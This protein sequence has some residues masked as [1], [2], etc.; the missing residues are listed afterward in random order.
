MIFGEGPIIKNI[1]GD[2]NKLFLQGSRVGQPITNVEGDAAADQGTADLLAAMDPV[3]QEVAVGMS[4]EE[5]RHYTVSG[6]PPLSLANSLGMPLRSWSVDVSPYQEGAG[7]PAPDNVRPIHGTNKLN[8]FVAD[9]Y[10]PTAA[11]T[12]VIDVPTLSA[13]K[14]DEE[15]EVGS[16]S[17]TG[18]K[19]PTGGG[20]IRSANKIS[21]LPNTSYYILKGVYILCQYSE[22]ED[23]ISFTQLGVDSPSNTGHLFTTGATTHYITFATHANY[24]STYNHDIAIN[25]PSTV[26]TY[27]PYN[28]TV[29]TGTIGSEGGESRSAKIV[30]TGTEDFYR[31]ETINGHWRF[32]LAVTNVEKS[33]TPNAISNMYKACNPNETYLGV[34]GVSHNST[35]SSLFICDEQFTTAEELKTFLAAQYAASTP[36]YIVYPLETPTT[37]A[38]PSVTIPTP[39]GTATTWA[40]AEDGTVESME[41][42]YVGKA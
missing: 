26:T 5:S 28:N 22:N 32:T 31:N 4:G 3:I 27:N 34:K 12:A 24:G 11:P 21:V 15:W 30:L 37:F 7:D 19:V 38:V 1:A 10:D 42:T 13:N 25:Y 16:Y 39:T 29:Y 23:F 35:S 17:A 40:T 2:L 6:T 9:S 33:L 36:V 20:R 14:W 18:Q 41:V 8:L